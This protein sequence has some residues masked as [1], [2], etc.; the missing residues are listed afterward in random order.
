MLRIALIGCGEHSKGNHAVP[1]ARYAAAHTGEISLVAACDLNRERAEEF[2]REHGFDRAYTDVEKMLEDEGIDACVSVM[3]MDR[4]AELGIKLLERGIPCVIE[5][6]LGT[7]IEQIERLAEVARKT[8]TPHMVSVN[9][10]FMPLLNRARSLAEERGPLRYIRAS[11]LR[12]HRPEPDFIWSTALHAVDA[13]RHIAGEV[14]SFSTEVQKR[15][16]G[17][18]LWYV[19]TM[20][21]EG[22]ALGQVEVLT[23][24]GSWEESYE[25]FCDGFRAQVIS[26]GLDHMSLRC[27]HNKELVADE[28]I[29]GQENEDIINGAYDETVNFVRAL[30]TGDRLWPTIEEVLP[31][32]RIC[33]QIAADAGAL[34]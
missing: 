20:L 7:S 3:P 24:A 32:S 22:G 15:E 21:F 11:M 6:P 1:L 8:A 30:R 18:P 5:K 17:M 9:R 31:S 10:R 13:L 28:T 23:T 27:W 26:R 4:I 29:S 12:H 19:I 25:L 2:C 14:S 33:F 34:S 16:G